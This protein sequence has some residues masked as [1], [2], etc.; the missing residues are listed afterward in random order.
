MTGGGLVDLRGGRGLIV[1]GCG[2]GVG[3]AV[4][5]G[6]IGEHGVSSENT[7]EHRKIHHIYN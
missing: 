3:L 6:E 1:T 2:A 4:G 7:Q 5:F